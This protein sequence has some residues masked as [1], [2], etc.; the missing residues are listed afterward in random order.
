MGFRFQKR[1]KIAPGVRLNVSK[2]GVSTSIGGRG[3]T[4]NL[5][6]KGVRTT[7]GLPGTGLSWSK[8]TGWAN[9][10]GLKPEDE[11]MQ[12][13]KFLDQKA[14]TFNSLSPKTNKV[15]ASWNKA[16]E[17]YEGGRGPSS[18]KFQTLVKRFETAM[19]GYQGIKESVDEQRAALRAI[20]SRLNGMK[21]GM[22]SGRLKSAQRDLLKLANEHEQGA[23]KLYDALDKV[24]A[25]VTAELAAAKRK[26]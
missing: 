11:L 19:A 3:A 17:S 10:N 13:G 23:Q 16:V 2:S 21:F 14:K 4:V 9:A 5:N 24:K 1:I 8:Q 12:L 25:E 15:S 20:V 18:S 7:V 22:F 26:M 6:S